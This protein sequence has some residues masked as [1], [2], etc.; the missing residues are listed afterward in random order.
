MVRND[1]VHFRSKSSQLSTDWV[2]VG[3]DER[4]DIAVRLRLCLFLKA[5]SY[6]FFQLVEFS[7]IRCTVWNQNMYVVKVETLPPTF[8]SLRRE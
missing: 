1:S 6:P 4:F 3:N 7:T 5:I 8:V 2:V